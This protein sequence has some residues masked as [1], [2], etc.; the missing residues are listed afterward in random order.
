MRNPDRYDKIVAAMQDIQNYIVSIE[1]DAEFKVSKDEVIGTTLILEVTC[2]L[3][4]LSEVEQFCDAIRK[5]D[6]IDFTPLANGDLSVM[7]GFNNAYIPAPPHQ[8]K[9]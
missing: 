1:D 4:S 7:F 2:T 5:A 6:T 9:K 8:P 3:L